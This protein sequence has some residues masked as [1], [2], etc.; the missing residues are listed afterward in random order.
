MGLWEHKGRL[1]SLILLLGL[2]FKIEILT[3]EI[4]TCIEIAATKETYN[5]T[6][7]FN[8]GLFPGYCFLII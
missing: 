8:S 5:F 3:L 1:V 2:S 7:F 4:V 6:F